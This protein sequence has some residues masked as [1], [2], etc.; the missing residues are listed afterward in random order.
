MLTAL[1]AC[2]DARWLRQLCQSTFDPIETLHG[3]AEHTPNL[4]LTGFLLAILDNHPEQL[5]CRG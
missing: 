2:T 1:S 4:N 5:E 3:L